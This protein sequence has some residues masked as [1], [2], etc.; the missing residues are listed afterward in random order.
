LSFWIEERLG[1]I[2]FII[3]LTVGDQKHYQSHHK[4]ESLDEEQFHRWETSLKAAYHVVKAN[5][6]RK[7]NDLDRCD[8]EHQP[9]LRGSEKDHDIY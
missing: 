1:K 4:F 2:I 9:L 6:F 7:L 5:R 3:S 8:D